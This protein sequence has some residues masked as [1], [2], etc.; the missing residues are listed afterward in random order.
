MQALYIRIPL[1]GVDILRFHAIYWPAFLIAA[2]LE[3]P[4]QIVVHSHWTVNN[5][6]M[7][8]SLGN[9]IEPLSLANRVGGDGLRYFL[10]RQ[11]NCP[12]V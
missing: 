7:S 11:V 1:T 9:T 10:L 5:T 6:K 3:L 8:K 2:G 4:K 12:T